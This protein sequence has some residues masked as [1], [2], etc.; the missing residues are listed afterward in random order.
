M[1][2]ASVFSI[3]MLIIDDPEDQDKF[4]FLFDNY[5]EDMLRAA[6][7]VLKDYSLAED[8]V[9]EG[10]IRIARVIKSV[11]MSNN[12]RAFVITVAKNA[13][14][15]MVA[16]CEREKCCF[17]T[18]S[19]YY[20]TSKV[21]M[22]K[23]VENED[24]AERIAEFVMTLEPQYTEVFYMRACKGMMY[25]DMGKLLNVSEIALRKRMQR[26]R[27]MIIEHIGEY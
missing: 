22:H 15:D 14:R 1:M 3:C 19:T 27:E 13:A 5:Q 23:K 24:T 17:D 12:P 16:K 18:Y 25:K 20:E 7:S 6:Q 4:E 2:N 26:L 21:E 10:F 11:D 8:A 9:Q